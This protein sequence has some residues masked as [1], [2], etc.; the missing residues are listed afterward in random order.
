MKA[1]EKF[2]QAYKINKKDVLVLIYM[3]ILLLMRKNYYAAEKYLLEAVKIDEK[4][5]DAWFYL[6]ENYLR[7][8][9]YKKALDIFE[10]VRS[11]DPAREELAL[12][13]NEVKERLEQKFPVGKR[14]SLFERIFKK[15]DKGK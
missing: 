7:A 9:E 13:I 12:K 8:K 14:K 5:N 15:S 2:Q 4:N 11:L 10:T 6:G 1:M 3:G